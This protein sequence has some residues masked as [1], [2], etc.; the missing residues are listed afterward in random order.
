MQE[1]T[2]D[3]GFFCVLLENMN[4]LVAD[5]MEISVLQRK[6]GVAKEERCCKGG[7][8]LQRRKGVAKEERCYNGG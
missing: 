1:T 2:V 6:R 8:V 3:G 5:V 4:V 7:K